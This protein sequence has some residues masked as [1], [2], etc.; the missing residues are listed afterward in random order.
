MLKLEGL[1][2]LDLSSFIPGPYLTLVMADHGAEVIKVE[3]PGEGDPARHIGLSDGPDTV[4]FRNFNR[5]K[6]SIALNLKHD[7]DREAFL[8]LSE[9]ADVIIESWRP[10]V[11]KRLGVDYD[12][13]RARNPRIV[14]CS[15]TAFGQD[16]PDADR[17]AHDLVLQAVTGLLST[18]IGQDGRVAMPALPSADIAAGL[19]GLSGV[20][21]ALFARERSGFG[22]YIDI[23]MAEALASTMLNILGPTLAE[24]RQPVVAHERS[25][26]GSAFYRSYDTA[27]GRQIVLGGQELKFVTNLLEALDGVEFVPLARQGPGPH[28]QP[29]MAFLE[30]RFAA[31][32]LAEATTLLNG[33]DVCWGPVSNLVE[34]LEYRQFTER[35]FLLSDALGRRHIGPP[36]RFRDAPARPSFAIPA[37]G[38]DAP[39]IDPQHKGKN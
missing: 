19:H 11:A 9:S 37:L 33:I 35:G 20:L 6:K 3:Q 28:Q 23:S 30:A 4:F 12:A 24:G 25:T 18:N 34:G 29:L 27:D 10:G 21:M 2:V 26:G 31:M 17:P 5:G 22:D 32:T 36:V 1:R 7:I 13:V 16:G 8:T 15:I 38:Q 39:S 14:Y